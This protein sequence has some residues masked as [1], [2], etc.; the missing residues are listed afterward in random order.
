MHHHLNEDV[1]INPGD[2]GEDGPFGSIYTSF[3]RGFL[4]KVD[5]LS[6]IK[7]DLIDSIEN[8]PDEEEA[9]WDTSV[10]ARI[11][12]QRLL[13]TYYAQGFEELAIELRDFLVRVREVER[14]CVE[15]FLN[16]GVTGEREEVPEYWPVE[17]EEEIVAV[18]D[19]FEKD[20]DGVVE[21]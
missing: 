20:K 6:E 5:H 19:E 14:G 12:D 21:L 15:A 10:N 8:P 2:L 4:Q 17:V 13:D 1:K 16:G 3:S 7:R 11:V 9:E 18:V